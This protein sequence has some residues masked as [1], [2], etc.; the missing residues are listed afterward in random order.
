MNL[1]LDDNRMDQA[2]VGLLRKAGHTVVCSRDAAL[3]GKSDPLHL[4][5]AVRHGLAVLTADRVDFWQLHNL[6]VTSGGKHP[7]ILVVRFDN[8]RTR[9]MKPKH[10]VAA[11]GKL[12]RSGIDITTQVV[13]LNAWR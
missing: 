3:E 2:L 1:Y 5:Y 9:D 10:V 6:I 4:E 11:V 13:V 8:D 7:G 12:E